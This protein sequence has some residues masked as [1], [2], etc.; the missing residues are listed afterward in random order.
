MKNQWTEK[1]EEME[2]ENTEARKLLSRAVDTI[3]DYEDRDTNDPLRM[4]IQDFLET[5]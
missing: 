4:E 2:R 3:A 1:L 5:K